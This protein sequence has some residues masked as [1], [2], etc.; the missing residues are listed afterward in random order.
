MM[1]NEH[2]VEQRRQPQ[3]DDADG[4]ARVGG[5][6]VGEGLGPGSERRGLCV[7]RRERERE[8]RG[9]RDEV[10]CDWLGPKIDRASIVANP[11][12]IPS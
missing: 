4:A 3:S 7:L 6:G 12:P 5:G 10:G 2:R 11:A 8:R 1:S 9:E